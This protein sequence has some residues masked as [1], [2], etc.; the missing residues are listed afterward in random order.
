MKELWSLTCR[1]QLG[2]FLKSTWKGLLRRG[3]MCCLQKHYLFYRRSWAVL[4]TTNSSRNLV[5]KISVGP[6][7]IIASALMSVSLPCDSLAGYR[8][9][10]CWIR[11]CRPG[12]FLQGNLAV[13]SHAAEGTELQEHHWLLLISLLVSACCKGLEVSWAPWF[14]ILLR[15]PPLVSAGRAVRT[16]TITSLNNFL[17]LLGW[18]VGPEKSAAVHY[19]LQQDWCFTCNVCWQQGER[20]RGFEEWMSEYV[21]AVLV[22]LMKMQKSHWNFVS[23]QSGETLRVFGYLRRANWFSCGSQFSQLLNPSTASARFKWVALIW[24]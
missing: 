1:C 10:V 18:N 4:A 20:D 7:E 9:W 24:K 17:T 12:L 11:V 21:H 15:M 14:S 5:G 2:P 23:H 16:G 6:V 19:W 22:R 13:V 8:L 3:S